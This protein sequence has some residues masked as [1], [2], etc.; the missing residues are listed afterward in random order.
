MCPFNS[1]TIPVQLKMKTRKLGYWKN[2]FDISA[3]DADI[4]DEFNANSIIYEIDSNVPFDI[5]ETTGKLSVKLLEGESLDYE[6]DEKTYQILVYAKDKNGR[7]G[8]SLGKD[9]LLLLT[10]E[11]PVLTRINN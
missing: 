4:S 9:K 8:Q 1:S 10:V 3:T 11:S 7:G 2:L 5:D 6:S